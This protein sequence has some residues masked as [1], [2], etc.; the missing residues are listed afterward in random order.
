M[1]SKLRYFWHWMSHIFRHA[2]G[3]FRIREDSYYYGE[4]FLIFGALKLGYP[5]HVST[6]PV[7][8]VSIAAEFMNEHESTKAHFGSCSYENKDSC[9]ESGRIL[10][11]RFFLYW[12]NNCLKQRELLFH[13]CVWH[14]V[15]IH[16]YSRL[17]K[18]RR[19]QEIRNLLCGSW[20]S[21]PNSRQYVFSTN[22]L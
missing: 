11:A 22:T 20:R 18:W 5:I 7:S 15:Y 10:E 4:N 1:T 2:V 6:F 12:Y 14:R 19:F 17:K 16:T 13:V 8:C 21:L 9:L 3:I